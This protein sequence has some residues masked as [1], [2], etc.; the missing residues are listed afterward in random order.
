MVQL[1]RLRPGSPIFDT[2][3]LKKKKQDHNT[4]TSHIII[5]II[6]SVI[7]RYYFI[8]INFDLFC[9]HIKEFLCHQKRETKLQQLLRNTCVASV[10][11]DCS[12]NVPT[13]RDTRMYIVGSL[14]SIW[15]R[16]L[17]STLVS[18]RRHQQS[19]S[20]LQTKTR[21]SE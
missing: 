19:I 12:T 11:R 15:H 8:N 6:V 9:I 16:A 5:Y 14:H 17:N 2:Y 20:V 13:D 21:T 18:L 1:T 10:R 7:F 4:F 3:T